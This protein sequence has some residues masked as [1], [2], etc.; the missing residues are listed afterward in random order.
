MFLEPSAEEDSSKTLDYPLGKNG[1]GSN[2]CGGSVDVDGIGH[3]TDVSSRDAENGGRVV[4]SMKEDMF[5]LLWA[6]KG[7]FEKVLGV[8]DRVMDSVLDGLVK[9]GLGRKFVGRKTG[10]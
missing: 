10:P 9:L 6:W 4:Q 5:S 1:A 3:A 8:L 7:G 2:L